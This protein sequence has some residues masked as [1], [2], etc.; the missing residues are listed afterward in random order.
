MSYKDYLGRSFGGQYVTPNEAIEGMRQCPVGQMTLC[1]T[2][3]PEMRK[4][5]RM[6]TALNAQLLSPKMS[7]KRFDFY[8]F[9]LSRH[10][11]LATCFSNRS[12][13]DIRQF[14]L[15]QLFRFSSTMQG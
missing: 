13:C 7:C 12:R 6:R 15:G 5:V 2:S 1:V 10:T 4:C 11:F 9:F 14:F 3:E 8:L